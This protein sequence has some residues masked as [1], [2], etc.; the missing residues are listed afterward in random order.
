GRG[1]G[2][3]AAGEAFAGGDAASR[4]LAG[5]LWADVGEGGEECGGVAAVDR[6]LDAG[7]RG[8]AL[9]GLVADVGDGGAGFVLGGG[10][11][12]EAVEDD[13]DGAVLGCVGAGCL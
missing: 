7:D 1:N 3:P 5:G 9:G 8:A 12:G 10:V 4:A 2:A 11:V 6:R 13:A